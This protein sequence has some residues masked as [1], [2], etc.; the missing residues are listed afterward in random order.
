MTSSITSTSTSPTPA[1][2]A[3]EAFEIALKRLTPAEEFF[4][5]PS[6]ATLESLQKWIHTT[7]HIEVIEAKNSGMQR[8][9][10]ENAIRAISS[11][12]LED[13]IG[14]VT[15]SDYARDYFNSEKTPSLE[16][17]IAKDS[18]IKSQIMG[19]IILTTKWGF[20][21]KKNTQDLL[22]VAYLA[23]DSSKK[24]SGV[25]TKL[26]LSAMCKTKELGKR[27]LALE[28]IAFGNNVNEKRGNAKIEFY[29]SFTTRFK[30]PTTLKD[31]FLSNRQV[32]AVPYYDLKDL[33]LPKAK[34]YS[35]ESSTTSS[36]SSSSSTSSFSTTP[37]TTLS[38][39]TPVI[40]DSSSAQS[41][42]SSHF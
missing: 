32:H 12:E 36:S 23:V 20:N 22:F 9:E 13:E 17:L 40:L 37:A 41:S 6:E 38:I 39:T 5:Q 15:P 35:P 26:M 2:S 21:K 28:Y 27:Y 30:I 8:E 1:K 18:S 31:W 4:N 24:R 42:S 16:I 10:I 7:M 33:N 11:K 14:W 3:E 29:N 25:G 19:F 34:I